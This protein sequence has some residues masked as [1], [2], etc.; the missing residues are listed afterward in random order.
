MIPLVQYDGVGGSISKMGTWNG[1][2][3]DVTDFFVSLDS[4]A[5]MIFDDSGN[6]YVG[7]S[8]TNIGSKFRPYFG[9]WMTTFGEAQ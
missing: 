6:I 1:T 4:P 9:K 2:S 7:G 5:N 3:W 8:F